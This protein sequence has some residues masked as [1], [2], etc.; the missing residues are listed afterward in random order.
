MSRVDS[1][2]AQTLLSYRAPYG[3]ATHAPS[4]Q[5]PWEGMRLYA[6]ISGYV[7]PFLLWFAV[8]LPTRPVSH[9]AWNG[10]MTG[11]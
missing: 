10:T 6:A 3:T 8:Y 11:V 4:A 5:Q 1:A 7:L 2:I 9:I